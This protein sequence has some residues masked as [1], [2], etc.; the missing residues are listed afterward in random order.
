MTSQ[1][2]ELYG[3]WREDP[4]AFWARAGEA[5]DWFSPAPISMALTSPTLLVTTI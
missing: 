2:H 5:I 1:Y 4:E 3:R